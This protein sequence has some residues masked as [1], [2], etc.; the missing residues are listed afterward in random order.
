MTDSFNWETQSIAAEKVPVEAIYHLT[1][2]ELS[3]IFEV[4][5]GQEDWTRDDLDADFAEI[6]L[7]VQHSELLDSPDPSSADS[8]M[9]KIQYSELDDLTTQRVEQIILTREEISRIKH[10]R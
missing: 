9:T 1:M 5:S 4:P 10:E 2:A 8:T 6:E 7:L 3:D